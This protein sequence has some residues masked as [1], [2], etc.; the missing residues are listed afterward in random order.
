MSG[1]GSAGGGWS[2]RTGVDADPLAG[3]YPA[4]SLRLKPPGRPPSGDGPSAA[5]AQPTWRNA[6]G[7]ATLPG[8]MKNATPAPTQDV[9]ETFRDSFGRHAAT[10][11]AGLAAV[12]TE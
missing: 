11:L 6:P 12:P 1:N 9:P 3:G 5:A 2:V 8:T 7:F 10:V 4:V